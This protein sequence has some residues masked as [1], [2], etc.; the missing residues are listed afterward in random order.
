MISNC[1][2][3]VSAATIRIALLPGLSREKTLA[4]IQNMI[5][6]LLDQIRT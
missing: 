3:E 1:E 4:D 2:L 6:R 5:F